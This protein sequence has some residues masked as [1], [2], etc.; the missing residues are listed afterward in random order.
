[1][2]LY[3]NHFKLQ[4]KDPIYNRIWKSAVMLRYKIFFWLLIHDRINSR[5]FLKR[6]NFHIPSYSFVLCTLDTEETSYHLIW[7][8]PFALGCWDS[9][10]TQ[11]SRGISIHD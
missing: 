4:Q 8:C 7:D 6:K 5:N 3:R 11:R 9:I 1:M 10:T 2:V